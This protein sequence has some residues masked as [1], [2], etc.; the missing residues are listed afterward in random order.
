MNAA[1]I[2]KIKSDALSSLE[3]AASTVELEQLELTLFGRKTG[4]ITDLL[5]S[6]KSLPDEEKKSIG[7]RINELKNS[8]LHALE[9]KK[10]SLIERSEGETPFDATE[11]YIGERARGSLHPITHIQQELEMFF[12]QLGFLVLDGPELDSEYYNFES[13]NIPADHPAR[14][15]QD[16]FYIKDHPGML[17]RTQT[18]AVQVRAM[19]EYGAPLSAIVP[20][21]CFRNEATDARHEHTFYQLEGFVVG[22][23][24]TFSHLKG[25]LEAVARYLYGQKTELRLLP[26]FYPFVEPGVRGEVTCML[27]SGKGCRVCKQS[28]FL[29]IFGAGMIHPNVLREGGLDPA[30]ISGLAFGLGLTRLAMLKYAIPDVR[31]LQSGNLDF[32]KQF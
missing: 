29:E 27:C 19:R 9:E 18:S 6:I 30:H 11:P 7:H 3:R 31:L 32:L 23:K 28:G 2:E 26:K 10:A 4:T 24:I 17:M 13:L 20:G 15:M 8:L 16:T 22:K 14:D 21:R 1:M 12:T 25:I 5:K